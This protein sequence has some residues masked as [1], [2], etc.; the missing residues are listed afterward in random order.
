MIRGDV[1]SLDETSS[2]KRRCAALRSRSC[3]DHEVR[4]SMSTFLAL[5]QAQCACQS[6]YASSRHTAFLT[7]CTDHIQT[8]GAHGNARLMVSPKRATMPLPVM[9]SK[10]PA[11]ASQFCLCFVC[12]RRWVSLRRCRHQ[13]C[14]AERGIVLWKAK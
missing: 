10:V 8:F 4:H 11:M 3:H 7:P 6:G 2:V 9:A 13:P 1:T 12:Q 5:T 14:Q